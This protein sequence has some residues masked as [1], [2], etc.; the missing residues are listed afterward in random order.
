MFLGQSDVQ[1]SRLS[2]V[3]VDLLGYLPALSLEGVLSARHPRVVDRDF[4]DAGLLDEFARG[5]NVMVG[6]ARLNVTFWEAPVT[7]WVL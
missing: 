3:P 1:L 5:S 6:L 4:G 2:E 7:L